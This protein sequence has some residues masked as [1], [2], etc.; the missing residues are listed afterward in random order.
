VNALLLIAALAA[1][2]EFPMEAH[3]E[4]GAYMFFETD[5]E[6]F[7]YSRIAADIK[8]LRIGDFSWHLGLEMDTYMGK[9][10]N[11]PEMAFNIYGGHWNIV[12]QFDYLIDPVLIRL[13]TDH[14]CFHNIDM[15]D[16]TSEYMNNIKL[17]AQYIPDPVAR[18][19][20]FQW[21]PASWPSGWISFG[22]YRPRS[23]SFQKG[24]DFNWS[25][26]G[27][28]DMPLVAWRTWHSGARL[29]S[30]FFFHNDGSG[31]SRHWGE[32]Y[33]RYKAPVGDFETH[34]T[35]YFRD[36]Q[37]FRSL[38]NETYWGIRFLW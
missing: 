3:G 2:V 22:L 12:T 15:E 23:E 37:P 28:G 29:H 27:E 10:W 5:V 26:Q 31:S 14:E 25:L 6:H 11:S 9:N 20:G 36:T 7:V 4:L 21:F 19:D 24:H 30:D 8:V 13:Y 17:G 35:H 38:E 32:I 16:S 1:P 18:A 34:L 33:M